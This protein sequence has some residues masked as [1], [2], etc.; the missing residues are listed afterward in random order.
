[1]RSSYIF[2]PYQDRHQS[3]TGHHG[4]RKSENVAVARVKG[5]VRPEIN[6]ALDGDSLTDRGRVLDTAVRINYRADSRVCG[7]HLISPIFDRPCDAHPQMLERRRRLAKPAVIRDD[8]N[9]LGAALHELSDQRRE[10][11]LVTNR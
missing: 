10:N 3:D 8:H 7:T 11:A 9:Q 2:S 6:F 4:V 5:L 1:M